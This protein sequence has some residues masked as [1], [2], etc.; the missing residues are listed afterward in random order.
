MIDFGI[1]SVIA[2]AIAVAIGIERLFSS[3]NRHI[4]ED[5]RR[6]NA[7]IEALEAHQKALEFVL[8]RETVQPALKEF[9]IDVS[10]GILQRGV[11]QYFLKL[12]KQDQPPDWDEDDYAFN[13]QLKALER[14]DKD[15]YKQ[16]LTVIRT[17]IAASVL[18]WPDT[19][20]HVNELI[21][22]L[23]EDKPEVANLRHNIR[24]RDPLD[25]AY[26]VAA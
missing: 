23:A 15:A 12:L 26:Q 22:K 5:C 21:V 16:V 14:R 9:L 13:E 7:A 11:A 4:M 25:D 2:V 19:T 17:G 1:L 3:I 6:T 24:Y 10:D 8:S 18:Q 20:K